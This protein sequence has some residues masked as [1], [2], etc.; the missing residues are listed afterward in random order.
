MIANQ[1]RE[2]EGNLSERL[3]YFCDLIHEKAENIG[4]KNTG[5]F[6]KNSSDDKDNINEKDFNNL[7]ESK[8]YYIYN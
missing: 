4:K 8:F 3:N 6:G 7:S 2:E 1:E 5:S